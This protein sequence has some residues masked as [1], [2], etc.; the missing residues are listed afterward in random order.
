MAESSLMPLSERRMICR[1]AHEV[2][3]KGKTTLRTVEN[4]PRRVEAVDLTTG[5]E[6]LQVGIK[7]VA[8]VAKNHEPAARRAA[9]RIQIFVTA[10]VKAREIQ[11]G[12][13]DKFAHVIHHV[14]KDT[15]R[16]IAAHSSDVSA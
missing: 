8:L 12:F 14:S 9:K 7:G 10:A 3:L 4:R 13:F 6:R 16:D 2:V 11:V 5:N 1:I 15:Y